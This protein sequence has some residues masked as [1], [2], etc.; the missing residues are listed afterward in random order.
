M[1]QSIAASREPLIK[2]LIEVLESDLAR[3]KQPIPL[4]KEAILDTRLDHKTRFGEGEDAEKL[5]RERAAFID[6]IM[7]LAWGRFNWDENKASWRKT[8]ISLLAVGGYGRKELHPH[9]DIDLLILLERNSYDLHSGNI[10]SFLALLWDIGLEVGHSVRSVKE[11]RAQAKND[12]T[13]LTSMMESRTLCGDDELS[14]RMNA[15][16][17]P[18]KIWSP[19]AFYRAKRKEQVERHQKSAHTEYSLEPN[20]KT[21]PGGLRDIQ[22]VMWIA[23]RKF[24]SVDFEDLVEQNFLTATESELLNQG[25]KFLWKIRFGLH[26][27]AGR[28]DD[29][30]LFEHQQNL[31][32]MF[33]YV[34]GDQLAVEQFMQDYYRT[35]HELSAVNELLLQHFDEAIVRSSERAKIEPINERFRIRNNYLEVTSDDIFKRYP[36]ALLEMFVIMGSSDNIEGVRAA[37]IRLVR[38][39]V[40]LIDEDFRANPE[41][42]KL[43]LDLLGC[44][45]HLFTQLRRMARYGILGAYLPEFGRVIGQMQ[46][47]LFHIYT[48]DAHTLQVVRNMRRFRYKN[49]EQQ[50]P[51]AAHIHHRLPKVE[52]LYVAGLYHDIAK[53]QGGDHSELGVA[54]A[55]DFCRRHNLGTWDTNL[56]CWLVRN[57]LVMSTT[58]QRKDIQDP[59]VIREFT[60]FV[61]DQVRLDY[62]YALTVADINATNPTLWN[63]WRASLMRHLYLSTKRLLRQGLE[64][65]VDRFHYITDTQN[66][67]LERLQERNI[68]RESI[69]AMWKDVDDDYFLRESV[70]DIVWHA[71]AISKHS[72]VDGPLILIRDDTLKRRA[73]EG[74]TQ[75][76]VYKENT[77]ELFVSIVTALDQLALNVVDARI[78]GAANNRS[79]YTFVVLES[80]G[81]P[82]GDRPGRIERIRSTLL[83]YMQP[84]NASVGL[85]QRRTPRLL[86]QF[87][88]K[89]EVHLREDSTGDHSIL[90]VITPDRPGLLS[91]IA[92]IFVDL[93]I[94]LQNA[95]ITTLGERVE[96]V[97]HITD[98][99]GNPIRDETLQAVLE[100]RIK[101]ELDY[102]IDKV[103]S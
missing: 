40:D 58:A 65:H 44:T 27:L 4:F 91:I 48:V 94:I 56:V 32:S 38:R 22:T 19:K 14:V 23:R 31:A 87:V 55:R 82:I 60:L 79:F 53:G 89:T 59:E 35:A 85:S 41:S 88:L 39:H 8:R 95:K 54:V 49:Q 33:G 2:Y 72:L 69:L 102:H 71:E 30:L 51:I 97:F 67:A 63:S 76:F 34:D 36:Q 86:K 57:H 18:E 9:S 6:E 47:D 15:K 99:G 12:V 16:I 1:T 100:Q 75:I 61:Q 68:K 96:D 64:S 42:A 10:Q 3:T 70:H 92:N 7:R 28:D 83:K 77:K 84:G 74:S 50:F 11:C 90:E 103:A 26:L 62:L 20:V 78:P 13:V 37:T 29:R 46:F 45:N 73:D 93:D 52:L 5:V 21:S 81:Q 24:G 25:R 43:F 80:N 101:D 98:E 17:A 66:R